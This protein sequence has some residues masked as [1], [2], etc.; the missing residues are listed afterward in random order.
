[1]VVVFVEPYSVG[2]TSEVVVVRVDEGVSIYVQLVKKLRERRLMVID[3]MV[4]RYGLVVTLVIP[5][6]R[7]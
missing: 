5:R 7:D 2:A 1:M 6:G 3:F 4:V